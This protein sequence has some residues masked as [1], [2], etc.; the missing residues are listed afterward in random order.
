MKRISF[1]L[2]FVVLATLWGCSDDNDTIDSTGDNDSPVGDVEAAC[3]AEDAQCLDVYR[4]EAC[5]EGQVVVTNCFETDGY[6]CE[7]GACV[8]PWKFGSPEYDTTCEDSS[9]DTSETLKEKAEYFD[10][11]ITRLHVHPEHKLV[12]GIYL[13]DGVDETTASQSD[14][15]EWDTGENDGLWTDTYVASQAFRYAVTG[16]EEALEN[17]RTTFLGGTAKQHDITGV[18]GLYTREYR[19]TGLEGVSSCPENLDAYYPDEEKDDNKWVKID[20]GCVW[21]VDP[22]SDEWVKSSHCGLDDFNGYCFL[23]NVSQDEYAGHM[24]ALGALWK[25]VDDETIR[26]RVAELAGAVADHLMKDGKM[27]FVDWDGRVTEHGRIYAM[28]LDNF[29][30]FNAMLALSW[31]SIAAGITERDDIVEWYNDCLLQRSGEMACIN[32]DME[33]PK[34]YSEHLETHGLYVGQGACKTNYNNVSMFFMGLI[35]YFMYEHRPVLVEPFQQLLEEQIM[36]QYPG[37]GERDILEQL[38]PVLDFSFAAFKDLR[39]ESS[40]PAMQAV[41]DGVCTLRQFPA[42]KHRNSSNLEELY[43][44]DCVSRLDGSNAADVIPIYERCM[45]STYMWTRNPYER[46]VCTED[47]RRLS[48][49]IDYLLAYWMGRYFGYIGEEE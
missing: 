6:Y 41:R 22:S 48:P 18:P 23:D 9:H 36:Q 42:S 8:P 46:K 20:E 4:M 7:N 5:V 43:E 31:F 44:H 16:D 27:E 29:P 35:P 38:N 47:T 10:T 34:P 30:G 15:Q 17:I 1:F 21:T 37:P 28:A 19:T 13:N 32:Q 39:A 26:N 24:L 25:L 11:I 12:S 45:T 40:G 33:T 3:Q 2:F 14:V 49:P